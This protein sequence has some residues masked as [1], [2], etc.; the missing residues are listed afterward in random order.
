MIVYKSLSKQQI[1]DDAG[2]CIGTVRQWCK[3]FEEKMKP[4]GYVRETKVLNPACVR[5]LA[6]HYCF[7]PHNA[8]VI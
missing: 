6:E 4:F 5:M 8:K 7:F 3:E 2:V 1:A